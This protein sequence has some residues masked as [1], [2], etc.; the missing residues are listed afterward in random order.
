MCTG[1]KATSPCPYKD[2]MVTCLLIPW[3]HSKWQHLD[4]KVNAKGRALYLKMKD[5]QQIQGSPEIT[6][7]IPGLSFPNCRSR[8][9]PDRNTHHRTNSSKRKLLHEPGNKLVQQPALSES[10]MWLSQ[11]RN[12]IYRHVSKYLEMAEGNWEQSY[13]PH[14]F[15]FSVF[16]HIADLNTQKSPTSNDSRSQPSL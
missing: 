3:G 4:F 9:D 8:F 10:C 6:F 15:F 13:L 5:R 1:R 16:R 12:T 2:S 14:Y 11:F 7:C